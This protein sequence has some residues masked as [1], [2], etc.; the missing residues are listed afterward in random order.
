MEK[1]MK[2]YSYNLVLHVARYFSFSPF[3]LSITV[4]AWLVGG[5]TLPRTQSV[6]E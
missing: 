3:Y 5:G 6:V 4:F 1:E 2:Y